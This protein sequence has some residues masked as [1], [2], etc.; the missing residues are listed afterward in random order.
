MAWGISA[1]RD[2]A[3][4]A[5]RGWLRQNHPDHYTPLSIGMLL[6]EMEDGDR[7]PLDPI[8]ISRRE[9]AM[10]ALMAIVE[11]ACDE[12][13]VG[14]SMSP[15]CAE[16]RRALE[17]LP[18]RSLEARKHVQAALRLSRSN[19][20]SPRTD[21]VV[22]ALELALRGFAPSGGAGHRAIRPAGMPMPPLPPAERPR[23]AQ[24]QPL[25]SAAR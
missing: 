9:R 2:E 20:G 19:D 18:H 13:S 23:A 24:R 7:D 25:A 15:V 11:F 22:A 5:V 21:A 14:D 8:G 16:V 3:R 6:D 1:D 17:C 10:G 4:L 12:I